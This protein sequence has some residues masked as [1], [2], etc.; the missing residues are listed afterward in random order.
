MIH[1]RLD[2]DIT[3]EHKIISLSYI[4]F[5]KYKRGGSIKEKVCTYGMNQRLWMQKED[6]TP[7]TVSIQGLM[8]S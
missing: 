1:P 3:V 5:L 8:F 6:T 7:P 2:I 4:M